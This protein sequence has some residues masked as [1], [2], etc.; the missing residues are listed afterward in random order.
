MNFVL[1]KFKLD[2]N[3]IMH[4]RQQNMHKSLRGILVI[5]GMWPSK[6]MDEKKQKWINLHALFLHFFVTSVPVLDV[7]YIYG[8]QGVSFIKTCHMYTNL[9]LNLILLTRIV[10]VWTEPYKQLV[11]KFYNEVHLSN[12][13][14]RTDATMKILH[15]TE[16]YCHLVLLFVTASATFGPFFY[17]LTPALTNF[18]NGAFKENSTAELESPF[19]IALPFDYIHSVR[20]WCSLAGL[21]IYVGL[22]FTCLAMIFDMFMFFYVIHLMGHL[23]VLVAELSVLSSDKLMLT[24]EEDDAMFNEMKKIISHHSLMLDA[25][26]LLERVFGPVMLGNYSYDS[27]AFCVVLVVLTENWPMGFIA[28]AV[29]TVVIF[30]QLIGESY[31]MEQLSTSMEEL[32]SAVC[33]VSWTCMSLRNKRAY[34]LLVLITQRPYVFKGVFVVVNLENMAAILKT[35]IS[36]FIWLK[37]MGSSTN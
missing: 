11:V 7:I 4:P 35:I 24:R 15:K 16:R 12:Y 23:E 17:V 9:I 21:F 29:L 20:N 13:K 14:F 31:A 30:F 22:F 34:Y 2:P 33:D 8:D 5:C 37:T 32:H 3:L 36:Y 10:T 26:H 1:E 6:A 27:V 25:L 19:Y 18:L 28:F